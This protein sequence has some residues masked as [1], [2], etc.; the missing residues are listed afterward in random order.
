VG[1]AIA[2]R[3]SSASAG[4]IPRVPRSDGSRGLRDARI[5]RTSTVVPVAQLLPV[6]VASINVFR[7]ALLSVVL[8][9]A[10][11]QNAGLLCTAW[12]VPLD[13]TSAPCPHQE[14]ATSPTVRGVDN[15]N[16]LGMVA[17]V[18]EDGRRTAR[19]S[20]CQNALIVRGLQIAQAPTDL[21]FGRNSG[22][23]PLLERRPLV[24]A[25]RI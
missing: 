19:A 6:K 16:N 14:P 7:A 20:D 25:R 2:V 11:G 4:K 10:V 8:T 1:R 12:C 21:W 22:R 17:F 18:R 23:L 5:S 9:L 3:D 24:L 15:C 13:A